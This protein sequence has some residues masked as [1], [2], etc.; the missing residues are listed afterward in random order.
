[1]EPAQTARTLSPAAILRFIP[2]S[3]S[4]P[5]RISPNLLNPLKAIART[6]RQQL[7]KLIQD[8]PIRICISSAKTIGEPKKH[9]EN[10][11]E[12]TS[13][14][15][16]YPHFGKWLWINEKLIDLNIFQSFK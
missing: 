10:Y 6:V 12:K 15:V 3:V 8:E 4:Q 13:N 16:P 14:L 1:M 11:F 7:A 2:A 5:R 9:S